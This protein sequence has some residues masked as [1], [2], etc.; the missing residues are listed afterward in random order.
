MASDLLAKQSGLVPYRLTVG[1]LE[2]MI[3]AGVFPAEAHVELLGGFLVDKQT[4]D[5]PHNF[6]VGQL[7]ELLRGMLASSFFAR[8]EKPVVLG[9]KDRPE[10]DLVVVRGSRENF[11]K[12]DPRSRNLALIIE[13]ADASYS[14]D[15]GEKWRRY[16]AAGIPVYWIV[17]LG[18]SQVEVY[19]K[20]V[21]RG[22][23]ARYQETAV[24]GTK[25]AVEV[26]IDGQAI[27]RIDVCKILP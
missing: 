13:V 25:D 12:Q 9:Q 4:K 14:K 16:A 10:P 17:N 1:Q 6:C 8:E 21:G 20:P 18:A 19:E 2:R 11:R 5:A 15:P 24:F 7:G 27:G 22:K 23:A 26:L 3:D